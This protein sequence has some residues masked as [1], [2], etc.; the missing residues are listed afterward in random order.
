MG[1]LNFIIGDVETSKVVKATSD[2]GKQV[3]EGL[4]GRKLIISEKWNNPSGEY[5]VGLKR[6][7]E[8]FPTEL[9]NRLKE[10]KYKYI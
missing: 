6:A 7:Y 3:I 5:R 2:D 10:V 1:R 9:T 4:S 8:L